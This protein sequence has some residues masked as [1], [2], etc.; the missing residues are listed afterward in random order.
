L[1]TGNPTGTEATF[2]ETL[3]RQANASGG[4]ADVALLTAD[5]VSTL[6]RK[7]HSWLFDAVRRGVF[8]APVIRE[9]RCTRWRAST[10]RAHLLE[11]FER[12]ENDPA[13]GATTRAKSTKASQA[14]QA[15]RI[16]ELV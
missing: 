16:A 9:P 11:L 10:V 13:N 5:D 14:A 4:L 15:K 1:D 3:K 12:A 6:V 7:S 8:P 2:I